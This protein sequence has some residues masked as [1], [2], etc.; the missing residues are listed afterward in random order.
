[1]DCPEEEPGLALTINSD[2]FMKTDKKFFQDGKSLAYVD[3]PDQFLMQ[4]QV[5]GSGPTLVMVGGGTT[6]ALSWQQHVTRLSPTRKLIRLQTLNVQYGLE[7]R[8]LPLNYSIE[9]ESHAMK[10]TLDSRC[11]SE[12][13]DVAGWSLGALIALDFALDNCDRVRT[14]TLIE[15]PA[16]W[17]LS[18]EERSLSGTRKG[19]VRE[20]GRSFLT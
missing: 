9:L 18:C 17:I 10:A 2:Q 4:S 5:E 8:P 19:A 20:P 13:V 14:L 15:P 16:A 12:P 7:N 1:L 3:A 6:G 11:L